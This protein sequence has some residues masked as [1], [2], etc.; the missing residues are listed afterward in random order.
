[1]IPVIMQVYLDK[2]ES[3]SC[4]F[5]QYT[6]RPEYSTLEPNSGRWLGGDGHVMQILGA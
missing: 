2:L 5:S 6:N 3:F 1:M 4:P